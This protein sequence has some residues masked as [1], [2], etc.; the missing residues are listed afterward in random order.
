MVGRS[1]ECE[2]FLDDVTVSRRHAELRCAWAADG[3]SHDLGSLNGIVRQPSAYRPARPSPEATR[4]R[5]A[6]TASCSSRP[7]GAES[8][9]AAVAA[10]RA[11]GHRRRP[12]DAAPGLPRRDD[13]EDPLPRVRGP[14]LAA[15]HLERLPQVQPRRRRAA[16][17]RARLPARPVPP[18]QGD[19][20]APRGDRPRSRAADRRRGPA[21]PAGARVDRRHALARVVP[22]VVGRDPA[23]PR[24][25]A[26]GQRPRRGAA[27]AARVVR[28]GHQAGRRTTTARRS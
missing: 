6:S 7:R 24:R 20:R 26:R 21:R 23:L 17:L 27:R 8:L 12:R 4:C 9:S 1:P 16:A 10:A 13:L 5:S 19:P 14:H 3:S 28:A 18:A 25:A 22:P 15:A 2:L 11:D